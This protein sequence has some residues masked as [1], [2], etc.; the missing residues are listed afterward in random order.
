M[1]RYLLDTNLLLYCFDASAP[2][3]QRRAFDVLAHVGTAPSAALP[4]QALS[5]FC[6][7]ALRKLTP[8]LSPDET[9]RQ[10]ELYAQVFP[11][12]PLTPAVILEAIR[13]VRDHGFSYYDAQIWATARLNQ[14]PV[15]LSED[16][17]TGATIEGVQ[18]LNPLEATF[19]LGAR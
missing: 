15:V 3:K 7:V 6:S 2:S 1:L 10:V 8:P 5:E 9:Y 14:I 12:F 11:I 17:P 18:F 19:D 13:G 16:F 4:A